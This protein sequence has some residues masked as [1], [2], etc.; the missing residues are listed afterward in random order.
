M[1]EKPPRLFEYRILYNAGEG[2]SALNNYHYFMALSAEQALSFHY[3]MLSRK[4]LEAQTF[5]VE[6]KNPYNNRWEN[7]NTNQF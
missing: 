7:E 3:A 6:K 1:K 2:N 5:S 4:N